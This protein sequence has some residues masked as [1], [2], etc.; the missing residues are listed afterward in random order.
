LFGCPELRKKKKNVLC[1]NLI[2]YTC[3]Y[4]NWL[5]YFARQSSSINVAYYGNDK[6]FNFLQGCACPNEMKQ[7]NSNF[8]SA[9]CLIE[10]KCP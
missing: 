3:I 5:I 7:K 4:K 9:W 2:L 10:V 1:I 6:W 8:T